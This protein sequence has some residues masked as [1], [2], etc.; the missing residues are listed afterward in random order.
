ML[1]PCLLNACTV[2]SAAIGF[3]LLFFADTPLFQR[4]RFAAAAFAAADA[5]MLLLPRRRYERQRC[6]HADACYARRALL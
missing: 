1:S 5:A 6:R 3:S 4:R 2:T